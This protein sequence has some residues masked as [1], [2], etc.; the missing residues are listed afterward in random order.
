MA[1]WLNRALERRSIAQK[2]IA[3]TTVTGFSTLLL[4][5]IMVTGYFMYSMRQNLMMENASLA[6]VVAAN[7]SPSLMFKDAEFAAQGLAMLENQEDFTSVCIYEPD[8]KLFTSYTKSGM[9][10]ANCPP[11]QKVESVFSPT[12]NQLHTTR[13]IDM[14]GRSVGYITLTS[15]LTRIHSSVFNLFMVVLGAFVFS[16]IIGYFLTNHLRRL[17]TDPIM[18]LVNVAEEVRNHANYNIRAP[19]SSQD[20]LGRLVETFNTMLDRVE[21]HNTELEEARMQAESANQAKSEFLA[22]MSHE[23][24]TPMHGILASAEMIGDYVAKGDTQ[25]V[26]KRLGV[27][28]ESGDRLMRLLNGLLDLSKLEAGMMEF[29]FA[30]T[31]LVEVVRKNLEF[32]EELMRSKRVSPVFE[33]DDRVS[34]MRLMTDSGRLGQVVTNVI[35]NA[36]KVSPEDGQIRVS[37]KEMELGGEKFAQCII[38]DD[39]PG[40]PEGE[41]ESIFEKFVQSSQTKTGAGGTGLGLSICREIIQA[42]EGSIFYQRSPEGKSQFCFNIPYVN[43]LIVTSDHA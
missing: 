42:H 20:E 10:K 24:R 26:T 33:A 37:V 11:P 3:I 39:G 13:E 25:L 5:A 12:T 32:F 27:I 2:L 16:S 9:A 7:V 23:L 18:A 29:N 38:Q 31:N 21:A 1:R 40:V 30:P 4:F 6:D 14:N 41:E 19:I 22:N 28:R 36:I 8:G 15:S 17:F 43:H 34:K 35:S